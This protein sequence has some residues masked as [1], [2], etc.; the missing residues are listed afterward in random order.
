MP[1]PL[2]NAWQQVWVSQD[3]IDDHY[4]RMSP[5]TIGEARWRTLNAQWVPSIGQ[6]LQPFSGNGDVFKWVKYSRDGQ[7]TPNKQTNKQTYKIWSN[8]GVEKN[9]FI[10]KKYNFTTCLYDHALA[11]E[12][13]PKGHKI[14]NF[15]RPCLAPDIYKLSCLIYIHE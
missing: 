6:N 13:Y 4:K 15:G 5:L 3:L 12:P 7:K 2:R 14:H 8:P 9:I 11:Q 1:A 10:E